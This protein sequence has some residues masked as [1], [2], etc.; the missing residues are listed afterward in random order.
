MISWSLFSYGRITFGSP[1]SKSAPAYLKQGG[2]MFIIP[3]SRLPFEGIIYTYKIRNK[4]YLQ[5]IMK[6]NNY[7][8]ILFLFTVCVLLVGCENETSTL[9]NDYISQEEAFLIGIDYL[10]LNDENSYSFT[11]TTKEAQRLNISE[12]DYHSMLNDVYKTNEFITK[13]IEEKIDLILFN[14]ESTGY[15]DVT[16]EKKDLVRLKS[17]SE[18]DPG[19]KTHLGSIT[20]R[21]QN[22]GTTQIFIPTQINRI[23]ITCNSVGFLQGFNVEVG[24]VGASGIGAIGTWSTDIT[25]NFSNT[26]AT[27]KI[28]TTNSNGGTSRFE[29]YTAQ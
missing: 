28:K 13:Q 9:Q 16:I 20:T 11:M 7:L 6:K 24:G 4:F 17:G 25:P 18:S 12:K 14:P 15:F 27:C 8:I 19:S 23:T 2:V 10:N 21:D 3:A 5:R 22:W 26:H 1:D 29:G